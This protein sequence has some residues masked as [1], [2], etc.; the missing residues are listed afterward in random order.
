VATGRV[1]FAVVAELGAEE[2]PISGALPRA[3]AAQNPAMTRASW[4]H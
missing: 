4:Q 1:H 3:A 2:V